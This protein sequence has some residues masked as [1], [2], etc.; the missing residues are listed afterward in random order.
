[1]REEGR[2][3]MEGA[4]PTDWIWARWSASFVGSRLR[5]D[6]LELVVARGQRGAAGGRQLASSS[7]LGAWRGSGGKRW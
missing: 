6:A 2:E 3:R 1:M 7:N 5:G 4:P